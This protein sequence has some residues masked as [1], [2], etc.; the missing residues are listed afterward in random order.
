MRESLL[1]RITTSRVFTWILVH[2]ASRIDPVLFK[3]TNGRLTM[4]GPTAFPM[5]TITMIGRKSGQTRT[6]HLATIEDN[7]D[8]LIVASAMGQQKHP[9]WRYNLE[10][11]PSVEVQLEGESYKAEAVML[12]DEEKQSVWPRILESVP[13]IQ[14]YETRTTR[15]IRVFR[16]CRT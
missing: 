9:G 14:V 13:Q 2:M 8:Q 10:A 11:N 5:A 6:V 15:N 16:L 1:V 7:G 12:S 3:A 4:F